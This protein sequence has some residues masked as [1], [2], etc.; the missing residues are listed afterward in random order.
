MKGNPWSS[1]FVAGLEADSIT[2]QLHH[3]CQRKNGHLLLRRPR[4]LEVCT[5]KQVRMSEWYSGIRQDHLI[6]TPVPFIINNQPLTSLDI[7]HVLLHTAD[8]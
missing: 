7:R 2:S 1:K 3:S 5:A 6:P 8:I 4:F